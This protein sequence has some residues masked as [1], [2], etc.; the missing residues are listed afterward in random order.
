MRDYQLVRWLA[1][2]RGIDA[3][4]LEPAFLFLARLRC[5]LHSI[6]GRDNNSLTFDAQ[7]QAADFFESPGAAQWM[8]G[9]FRHARELYRAAVRE[10]DLSEAQ[11]SSL[12]TQFKDWRTRLSNADFSVLRERVHLRVPHGLPAD[13]E[14]AL[15][16]FQFVARHGIRPSAETEER[17][18]LAASA[19]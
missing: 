5:F 19:I 2:L 14:L 10:L 16:L 18:C 7:E 1:R 3:P 8:R 15:R 17:I 9:Y 4:P 6:S 13:P 11:N 12:Y